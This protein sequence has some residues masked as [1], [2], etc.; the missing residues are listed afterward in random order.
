MNKKNLY[1]ILG[2]LFVL[3]PL[4]LLSE[5]DAWGEW[6]NEVYK[7]LIGFIPEG[8]KNAHSFSIIPDYGEGSV[9]MYYISAIIGAG[10]IYALLYFIVKL[11]KNETN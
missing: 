4:G 5:Y 2:V 9:I 1:I 7:K 11:K 8:I 10:A 6:D 3:L